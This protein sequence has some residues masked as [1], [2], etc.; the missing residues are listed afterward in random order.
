MFFSILKI[1]FSIL[2]VNFIVLR[3]GVLIK[4]NTM[5]NFF[6]KKPLSP[7]KSS[8]PFQ[9]LKKPFLRP[10][11]LTKIIRKNFQ[12]QTKKYQRSQGPS[13]EHPLKN[14]K[15]PKR[16]RFSGIKR[17]NLIFF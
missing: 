8:I 14:V 11:L 6:L 2:W 7:K 4:R 15:F 3:D 13:S 1:K 10:L 17:R 9:A 5:G 12:R 16:E